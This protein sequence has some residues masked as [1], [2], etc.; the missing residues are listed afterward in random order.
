MEKGYGYQDGFLDE[1]LSGKVLKELE[2]LD[3]DGKLTEVQQQK[4]TGYRTDRIHWLQYEALDRVKQPGLV[5]LMKK[6]ISIPFELNKKCSLYLQA[7]SSFQIACYPVTGYYKK[8]VDGGYDDTNNGR[9]ISAIFYVNKSWS[10]GD[11]GELRVYKRRPN[12]FE[13]EKARKEGSE[14][15]EKPPDEAVED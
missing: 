10:S 1:T 9:K 8:H 11:G 15:P 4:M 6:M 2:F 12:P 5:S 13:I 14:I 3:F 7:S